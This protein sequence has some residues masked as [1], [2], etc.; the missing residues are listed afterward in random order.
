M[1]SRYLISVLVIS[2]GLVA[3]SDN[4]EI[5]TQQ[6]AQTQQ[7]SQAQQAMQDQQPTVA[8]AVK[9]AAMPDKTAQETVQDMP[10]ANANKAPTEETR[11][12][13][14]LLNKSGKAGGSLVGAAQ[15]SQN[16]AQ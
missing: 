7:P 11:R 8:P 15:Q 12:M 13:A 4:P 16:A 1:I 10:F 6:P 9:A 5:A 3:C 14:D 2:G